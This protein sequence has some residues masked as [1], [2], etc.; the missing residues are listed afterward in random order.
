MLCVEEPDGGIN[1]NTV[2]ASVGLK[3]INDREM[4]ERAVCS[5]GS[6]Y[7]KERLDCRPEEEKGRRASQRPA[8]PMMVR[9]KCRTFVP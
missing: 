5:C 3:A 7:L 6:E 4:S 9:S 8:T 2:A 1:A